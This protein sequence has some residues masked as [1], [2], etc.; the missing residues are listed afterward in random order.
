MDTLARQ[1]SANATGAIL[2]ALIILLL[3][4]FIG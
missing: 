4:F 2:A 1:L 3:G